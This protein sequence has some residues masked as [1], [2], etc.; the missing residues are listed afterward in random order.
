MATVSKIV[1]LVEEKQQAIVI[2]LLARTESG[3]I[4]DSQ[5]DAAI[6]MAKN[7]LQLAGAEVDASGSAIRF[8]AVN[9]GGV[10]RLTATLDTIIEGD[11]AQDATAETVEEEP[12]GDVIEDY[13]EQA[14]T[15]TEPTQEDGEQG[16]G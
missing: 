12:T 15:T 5:L 16:N 14:P 8:N 1:S 4:L 13:P 2:C 9:V 6:A 11:P 3:A 7:V 10:A